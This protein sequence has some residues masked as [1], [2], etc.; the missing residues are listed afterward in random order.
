MKL[1]MFLIALAACDGAND[2]AP[3][4]PSCPDAGP[5]C[6]SACIATFSGNF[7]ASSAAAG[8]CASFQPGMQPSDIELVF[9]LA[10]PMLDAPLQVSIDLGGAPG[11]GTYSSETSAMWSALG[12]RSAQ[13]SGSNVA[14][15]CIYSAGAQ[16]VP[17]G[18]FAMTLT[19]IDNAAAHGE[20]RIEQYIQA[21]AQ[22]DC[23]SGDNETIDVQ[24]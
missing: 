13:A 9:A 14:G 5:A 4:A 8:N 16:A 18:S 20:L 11:P 17:T 24:F 19:S 2:V 21:Q 10:S 6:T 12:S 1:A 15:E 23:G 22:V 3:D 7:E